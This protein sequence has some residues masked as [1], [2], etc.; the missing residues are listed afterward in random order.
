MEKV[1]NKLNLDYPIE[2]LQ[3]SIRRIGDP[4]FYIQRG[5]LLEFSIQDKDKNL[6][7]S[8]LQEANNA[9]LSQ[10]VERQ[11]EE[12]RNSINFLDDNISRITEMLQVSIDKLNS[13]KQDQ[14]LY[15]ISL[16][17]NAKLQRLSEIEVELSALEIRE[18][19]VLQIYKIDHPVYQTLLNQKK[20][21]L[22]QKDSI[23]QEI[24]NLPQEEKEYFELFK[25]V[26]LNQNTLDTLQNR[27]LELSVV[28]A[29]KTGNVR[30][31]DNPYIVS[32]PVYPR[33]I[34]SLAVY[35]FFASLLNLFLIFLI[36]YFFKRITSVNDLQFK[37]EIIGVL[38]FKD[39]SDD[40]LNESIKSVVVQI[41]SGEK[42]PKTIMI[43]GATSGVG[44]S[45]VSNQ[46]ATT[47]AS[48]GKKVLLVDLDLRRGDL[49]QLYNL[50]S[51]DGIQKNEPH[52]VKKLN[53]NLDF[54]ARGSKIVTYLNTINSNYTHDL[55]S[56]S[57]QKYDFIVID[58]P[59]VLS[60]SDVSLISKWA[61]F[62]I[63]VARQKLSKVSEI[64][65]AINYF[66]KNAIE[67]NG[68]LLNGFTKNNSYY[69]YDYYSYRYSGAYE[70]ENNE[71]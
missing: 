28:E 64:E 35:F 53:D 51:S 11:S 41:I 63:L 8:I 43:T 38:P 13:F 59:P 26:E 1:V 15:D 67:L 12:A 9:F 21:F 66:D 62:N 42:V 29:S 23:N 48:L 60:V 17:A 55:L 25:D 65:F 61:D 47:L 20:F 34:E 10:N 22:E 7:K 45:F 70:Y 32:T 58:T 68:I 2:A 33:P 27:K 71:E 16:E 57:E 4:G 14:V 39:E 6:A 3:V 52:K 49:H 18:R 36:E 46:I 54:V 19:E 56:D 40:S 69:G 37:Q 31:I 44:K 5:G 50:K 24:S 30:V